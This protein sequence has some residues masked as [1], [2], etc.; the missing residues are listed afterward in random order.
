MINYFWYVTK[1][2]FKING[3]YIVFLSVMFSLIYTA[4]VITCMGSVAWLGSV[5]CGWST[6]LLVS[7][8]PVVFVVSFLGVSLIVTALALSMIHYKQNIK[9][10]KK[11][12]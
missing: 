4:G 9:G 3:W 1:L 8:I 6:T 2:N 5:T 11:D 10:K 7:M 12:D